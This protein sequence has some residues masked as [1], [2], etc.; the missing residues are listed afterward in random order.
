MRDWQEV[1]ASSVGLVLPPSLTKLVLFN[2]S[3]TGLEVALLPLAPPGLRALHVQWFEQD[4]PSGCDWLFSSLARLKCL[5]QLELHADTR[6]PLYCQWPPAGPVYSALAASSSLVSLQV[7][8]SLPAGVWPYVFC[9]SH[10]L[11]HL[12]R[13]AFD[14][15]WDVEW[16]L[17][18]DLAW[19]FGAA[20]LAALVSCCPGL[21]DIECMFL[22]PGPHVSQLRKLTDLTRLGACSGGDPVRTVKGLAAITQ[23]RHLELFLGEP[24]CDAPLLPLTR[25]T[26]LE[27]LRYTWSDDGDVAEDEIETEVSLLTQHMR[28]GSGSVLMLPLCTLWSSSRQGGCL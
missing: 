16:G 15:F 2:E 18:R 9:T 19:A 21:C 13:L 17:Q 6:S 27:F 14:D 7:D 26:E 1:T 28:A 24:T 4:A 22:T 25:L 3:E 20:D 11:P 23:L 10:Q 12:T 8:G 5:T